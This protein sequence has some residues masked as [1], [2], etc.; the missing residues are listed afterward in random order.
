MRGPAYRPPTVSHAPPRR[1]ITEKRENNRV[2]VDSLHPRARAGI[3]ASSMSKLIETLQREI[4]DHRF[5][6][7]VTAVFVVGTPF[8]VPFLFPE[9]TLAMSVF[10]GMAQAGGDAAPAHRLDHRVLVLEAKIE[11]ARARPGE[12]RDLAAHP[13][14]LKR[15]FDGTLHRLGQFADRV[16]RNVAGGLYGLISHGRDL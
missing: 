11:M 15:P 7:S 10:G 6:Y 4:A 12:A 14:P 5:A 16:L 3:Y 13:D 1:G 9:A 2:C 8:A